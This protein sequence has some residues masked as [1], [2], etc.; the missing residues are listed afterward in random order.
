M[1]PNR[2]APAALPE[3]TV[4][5]PSRAL[6]QVRS[7]PVV[8]VSAATVVLD[9]A[10]ATATGPVV[11]TVGHQERRYWLASIA[12]TIT[13]WAVL[14]A[15]EEGVVELDM[16]IGQPGCTMRHLLSHAG[17]YAFDGSDP[18]TAPQRRRIYSNTGIELA[19]DEVA[20]QAGMSFE[21]YL[22]DAVLEPLGMTSTELH[23]SPA[24][25]MWSTCAD[26]VRFVTEVIRP[27]LISRETATE[28]T[29][30]VFAELAGVLPGV[31]RYQHN[32][33]GLGFEVKGDK[34]PHWT[35]QRNSP[36]TF[37]HFGGAG[38]FVWV[39]PGAVHDRTVACVALTDLAFG[40]WAAEALVAWPALSDTV[41]GEAVVAEATTTGEPLG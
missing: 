34:A 1:W 36:Q 37:G 12:K 21:Q 29:Q 7:W 39:D 4:R 17:G 23:G 11:E 13:T 9:T 8:N 31:G 15:V 26:V 10:D 27:T 33:W 3:P 25:A 28:A 40:D 38:T 41:V 6:D 16:P 2:C 20:A 35:G 22:H 14:V 19:A 18:I 32:T 24:H 30:P 5:P